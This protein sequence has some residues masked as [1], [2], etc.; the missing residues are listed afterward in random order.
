M[1]VSKSSLLTLAV[2]VQSHALRMEFVAL[3]IIRPC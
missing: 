3:T 1:E 2:R